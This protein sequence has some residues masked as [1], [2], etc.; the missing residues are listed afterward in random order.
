MHKFRMSGRTIQNKC[1]SGELRAQRL[2]AHEVLNVDLIVV[3]ETRTQM[4]FGFV[5]IK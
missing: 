2:V 5:A 1:S 3:D 4:G